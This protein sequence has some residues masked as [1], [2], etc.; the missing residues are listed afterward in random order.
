MAQLGKIQREVLEGLVEFKGWQERC[1]WVY[2]N[3]GTTQRTLDA[4]VK[5]GFV[6]CEDG[7][8]IPIKDEFGNEIRTK[9][10]RH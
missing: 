5:R 1:G 8:Y 9:V 10:S 2:K 3:D 6:R 7:F 4:L